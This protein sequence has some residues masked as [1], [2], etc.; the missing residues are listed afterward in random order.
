[1]T[2][3]TPSTSTNPDVER[4]EKLSA[5]PAEMSRRDVSKREKYWVGKVA[6]VTGSSGGLGFAVAEAFARAGASVVISARSADTLETAAEE[7]RKLGGEVLA[8]PADVTHSEQVDALVEQA[9]ARFGRLDVLVNNVGK[10]A[11]GTA[12]ETTPDE[13]AQ[14]LDLN[15][16]SAVRCTR[17]AAPHLVKTRGHLVNIGSLSGKAAARFLGAYSASKFA[18]A[19]YTQQLR[20]ELADSGLHVLLVSPGPIEREDAGRRY[21]H[22]MEG[23]PASAAKPGGGAKIPRIRA[24]KLAAEILHACR[25]RRPELIYPRLARV[26]I[27]VI[28]L[29]PRL[30]DWLIRRVT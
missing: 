21:A 14:A 30:G 18:L 25:G 26:F 3:T 27:G 6:L 15:F 7:L 24:D 16:L 17:A 12:L 22:Q 2:V 29:F 4:G 9:I 8:V 28:Q 23:L 20:L 10:S 13:F 5:A 11:R 1:M 19:A